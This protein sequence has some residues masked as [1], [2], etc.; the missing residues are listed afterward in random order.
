MPVWPMAKPRVN[1][2]AELGLSNPLQECLVPVQHQA[3]MG[4][5]PLAALP[6][7][8]TVA[9]GSDGPEESAI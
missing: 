6:D 2:G 9:A 1:I 8:A 7:L 4:A 3:V 5:A